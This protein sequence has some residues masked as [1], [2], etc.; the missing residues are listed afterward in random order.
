MPGAC[1]IMLVCY[2]LLLALSL[3]APMLLQK[4]SLISTECNC[5]SESYDFELSYL[6]QQVEPNSLGL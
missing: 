1:T 4:S 5:Q 6:R 2:L 3:T